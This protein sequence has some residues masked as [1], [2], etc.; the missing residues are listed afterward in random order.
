V[1]VEP[2]QPNLELADMV[3]ER[4]GDAVEVHAIG[5]CVQPRKLQDALLE[6]ATVG[7]AI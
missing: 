4:C 6:G 2:R 7:G 1:V 5:D 3:A